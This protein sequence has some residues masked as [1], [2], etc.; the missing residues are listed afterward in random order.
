MNSL[1]ARYNNLM[2]KKILVVDDEP[3]IAEICQ[4]YLKA[5]GYEVI[6][7]MTGPMVY[8]Q[9]DLRNLIWSCST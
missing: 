6:T 1:S 5:A 3:K 8:L 7:A 4:D 2:P 9:R